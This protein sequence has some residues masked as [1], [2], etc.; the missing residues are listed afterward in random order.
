MKK[1][2]TTD[3]IPDVLN[4][5]GKE[6]P[7]RIP[8][9]YFDDFPARLHARLEAEEMAVV[10]YRSGYV[11][12][13]KPAL[14]LAAAFAAVFLLVFLPVRLVTKPDIL[15][16][17]NQSSEDVRIINLVEQV[18]DHTFFNWL[19]SESVIDN[20]DNQAIESFIASNYSDYDIYMETQK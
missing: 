6:L 15:A 20:S 3:K 14:G 11:R 2:K 7:F 17:Y 13:L 18:D 9:H 19:E 5:A 12:Y 4:G 8:D 1:M 16:K 10:S